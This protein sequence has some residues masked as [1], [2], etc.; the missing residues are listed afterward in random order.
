MRRRF[1]AEPYVSPVPAA[2]FIET[3]SSH[4]PSP[5]REAQL[6]LVETVDLTLPKP[7][8]SPPPV[9]SQSPVRPDPPS[10]GTAIAIEHPPSFHPQSHAE[11]PKSMLP[12]SAVLA[13]S[14]FALLGIALLV[15][16]RPTPGPLHLDRRT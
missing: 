9:T 8:E 15:R 3:A 2:S 14:L 10:V 12:A 1:A 5:A 16:R 6:F 13:F 4:V 11:S 7:V